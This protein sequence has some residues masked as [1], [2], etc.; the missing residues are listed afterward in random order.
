MR[1]ISGSRKGKKLKCLPSLKIRPTSDRLKEAFFSKIAS[2]IAA[3]SFLDC[4]AGCGGVG[5]EALSRGADLVVFIESNRAA[6]NIIRDNLRDCDFKD[7]A[8]LLPLDWK[9]AL[10]ILM[11]ENRVFDILF[12]NPPYHEF[13][14]SKIFE[15][16][17]SAKFLNLNS[18]IAVEHFR[19]QLLE[20]AAEL[21]SCNSTIRAGDSCI[22][23]FQIKNIPVIKE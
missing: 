17:S 18:L 21:F 1:I 15:Y 9:R 14:Y 20:P 12:F 22:S 2:R 19:H 10:K 6:C 13:S 16:L 5:I 7:K 3:C 4:F 11:Q 23:L 8:K